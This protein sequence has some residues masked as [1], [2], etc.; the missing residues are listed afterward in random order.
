[1]PSPIPPEAV[2]FAGFVLVHCAAVADAN[3][4][5]ELICPFAVVED[6]DGRR[7]IDFESETQQEA[8]AK[9]WASLDEWKEKAQRWAF[10]REGT[11]R[12]GNTTVDVL[13]VS[14]WMP[15]MLVPATVLQRF[16]RDAEGGLYLIGRA[17]LLLN[18]AGAAEQVD[19]WNEAA[20]LRGIEA[21]PKETR[22][23]GWKQQ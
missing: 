15:E 13:V 19:D 14:T 12:S 1:M 2:E 17:E 10:G 9:G 16:A 4:E 21:H 11:Y 22:W 3:R 6:G 23:S 20:L 5:G 7:A 18:K 8:V